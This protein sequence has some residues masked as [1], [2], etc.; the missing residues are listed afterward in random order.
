MVGLR[1]LL[2]ALPVTTTP[3]ARRPETEQPVMALSSSEEIDG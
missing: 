3:E 2:G 1:L